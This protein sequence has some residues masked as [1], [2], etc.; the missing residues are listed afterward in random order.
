MLRGKTELYVKN[1]IYRIFPQEEEK[2]K[3][4]EALERISQWRDSEVV[5]QHLKYQHQTHEKK[6]LDKTR[7]CS[8]DY[9]WLQLHFT[10]NIH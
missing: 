10:I 9:S 2:H 4:E 1:P 7:F 5:D 8:R 3:R 6:F